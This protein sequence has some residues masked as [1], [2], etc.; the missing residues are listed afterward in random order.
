M[1][2]TAIKR[3]RFRGRRLFSATVKRI[4]NDDRVTLEL[5]PGAWLRAIDKLGNVVADSRDERARLWAEIGDE[6]IVSCPAV[7]PMDEEAISGLVVTTAS[8]GVR[9]VGRL[10]YGC[11]RVGPCHVI[12]GKRVKPKR[13]ASSPSTLGGFD[14]G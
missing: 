3:P 12:P 6:L 10:R 11:V 2:P 8:N 13:A 7:E 14:A 1:M 4:G 9:L 5:A